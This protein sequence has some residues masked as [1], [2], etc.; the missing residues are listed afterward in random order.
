MCKKCLTID[1][2]IANY[3][4]KSSSVDGIAIAVI[5]AFIAD[6]KEEQVSLHAKPTQT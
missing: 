5:D 1:A 2:K 3:Q 6:L 4:Q